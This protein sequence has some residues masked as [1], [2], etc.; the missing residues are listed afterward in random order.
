M[1]AMKAGLCICTDIQLS[2]TGQNHL[3]AFKL[4]D[5][6]NPNVGI[7]LNGGAVLAAF[8]VALAMRVIHNKIPP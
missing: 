3:G 2:G 1:S 6:L 7:V 8:K 5:Q 4:I